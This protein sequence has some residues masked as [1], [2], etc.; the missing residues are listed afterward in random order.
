[1]EMK[2]TTMPTKYDPQSIEKGRYDW[3]IKGEFFKANSDESKQPYTIVI[4]PQTLQVS[5]TW[6]MLG[7]RHYKILLFV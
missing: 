3:W 4:P 2:E 6:G 5:Y 7:I 1:M